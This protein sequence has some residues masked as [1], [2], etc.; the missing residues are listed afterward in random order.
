M[1]CPCREG[2]G[3]RCCPLGTGRSCHRHSQ[4]DQ[5]VCGTRGCVPETQG[6]TFHPALTLLSC[7]APF[8][9]IQK[10]WEL[11]GEILLWAPLSIQT[12]ILQFKTSPKIS[13]MCTGTDAHTGCDSPPVVA[14]QSLARI[15]GG[16]QLSIVFGT[17][18]D[19]LFWVFFCFASFEVTLQR[20]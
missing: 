18:K 20:E 11:Q 15:P 7:W 1:A 4:G 2:S 12:E 19:S 6:A 13:V 16:G 17:L 5:A 10:F 14:W 9:L 8:E 3:A